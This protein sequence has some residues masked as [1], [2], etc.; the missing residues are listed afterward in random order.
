[1]RLIAQKFSKLVSGACKILFQTS[2]C[3]ILELNLKN[4][5]QKETTN[6]FRTSVYT[7]LELSLKNKNK[8]EAANARCFILV[9][10][11][12]TLIDKPL[13]LKAKPAY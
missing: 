4:K 6:L 1:M 12:A 13:P 2:V 3:T 9:D 10:G 7:I 5:N 11:A 8:K